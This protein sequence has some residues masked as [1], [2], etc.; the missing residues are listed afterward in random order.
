MKTCIFDIIINNA[1]YFFRNCLSRNVLVALGAAVGRA[2]HA[3]HLLID[4]SCKLIISVLTPK[5]PL[6]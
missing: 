6:R 5:L 4:E 1:V 3:A 2:V